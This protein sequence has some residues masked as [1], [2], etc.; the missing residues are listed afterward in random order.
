LIR[1]TH[2]LASFCDEWIGLSH[3]LHRPCK[4]R[5]SLANVSTSLVRTENGLID[6]FVRLGTALVNASITT[7]EV[8]NTRAEQVNELARRGISQD[9]VCSVLVEG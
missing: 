9:N 5:I 1:L 3:P 2:A 4:A 6:A 7:I 8:R